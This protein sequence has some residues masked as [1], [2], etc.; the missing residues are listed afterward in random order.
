MKESRYNSV[1]RLSDNKVMLYNAMKDAFLVVRVQKE[2]DN[3]FLQKLYDGSDDYR[4]QL[5]EAGMFL[6]DDVDEVQEVNDIIRRTDNDDSFF[7]LH[8]NPT[9]DCNFRCWYCYEEHKKGS[10]MAS[11]MLESIYRLID[12]E[13]GARR[14]RKNF[15]LAFFGGEPLLKFDDVVRPLIE[16]AEDVCGET[17]QLF[18]S[19]TSNGALLTD[20]IIDFLKQ[21]DCSFQITLDGGKEDHDKTRFAKG[22]IGSFDVIISNIKKLVE[23][24]IRCVCRVN[25][26]EKNH[27]DALN[28]SDCFADVATENRSLLRVDYQRVWQDRRRGEEETESEIRLDASVREA[29]GRFREAGFGVSYHKPQGGI[30]DSCYA[31]KRNHLLVNYNGDV[32]LC[33]ARDFKPEN[34]AGY[35]KPDGTVCWENDALERRMNCKF[36]RKV[37]YECR[38]APLCG[39]GCRQQA[40]EHHGDERC[41]YGYTDDDIDGI[42]LNRFEN[43]Y[44][45]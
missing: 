33:T 19:F 24:G 42:I 41:L 16:Y 6:C 20:E 30:W 17:T 10:G 27:R 45:K 13:V 34:R 7:M 5:E 4:R 28:L 1:I 29:I 40:M 2:A 39:G 43:L 37:C 35:L 32:F 8:I 25:Y 38:I 11:D 36:I 26:T 21:Y 22:G 31:D 12:C 18:V 3:N 23:S 44:V 9:L 15:R 14:D